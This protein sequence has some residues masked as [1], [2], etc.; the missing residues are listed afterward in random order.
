MFVLDEVDELLNKAF[1]DQVYN[2]LPL[3]PAT[4]SHTPRATLLYNV[5]EMRRNS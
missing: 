5:P 1:K 4:Q 3:P 2:A